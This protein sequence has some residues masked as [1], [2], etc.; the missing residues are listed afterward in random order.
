MTPPRKSLGLYIHVPF[1]KHECPYCDF[2]KLELRSRPARSRLDFPDRLDKELQLLLAAYPR[3]AGRR[4]ETIYFGGGTPST[5]VP[6]S[7]GS[8]IQRL[9]SRF[10]NIAPEVEITLEANPENLTAG[11]CAKWRGAGI[12]RLSIGI[13]SFQPR[14]LNLLERLHGP[15]LIPQVIE[16]AR[17]AGITNISLDLMFA[18]PGQTEEDW[19]DNLRRAAELEPRHLSFYG[20]TF[21][22]G[23]PFFQWLEAGRIDEMKDEQQAAMYLQ[24]AA[25]LESQGFEHYEISNFARPGWRSRH[26]QRYWTRGDVVGLGPGAHSNLGTERWA[27]PENLDAW[28]ASIDAGQLPRREVERVDKRTE[29]AERLFT[30][31]RRREGLSRESDPELF[32]RTRQWIEEAGPE[33]ARWFHCE[34]SSIC[35]TREG[36]LVSDA[37]IDAIL[38]EA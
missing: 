28:E 2:Y 20:L 35:P 14:E 16:N 30:A 34:E 15:D 23:T 33:G 31:L 27:N 17:Q 4:L 36:W 19:M 3:L 11:R 7:V 18:L 37:L 24:G 26:N 12:T 38:S 6:E 1:C 22:P 10:Q 13:Q 9:Q 8:L 25:F 21:H 32:S 5:L 29:A